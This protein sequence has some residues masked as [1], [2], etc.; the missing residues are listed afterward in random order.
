MAALSEGFAMQT[1]SGVPHPNYELDD[2]GPDVGR[3]WTLLA[4]AVE[5]VVDRLTEPH[6]D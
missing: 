5:A 6:P 1:M 2:M 4:V 3:D